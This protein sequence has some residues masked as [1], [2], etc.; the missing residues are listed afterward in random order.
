MIQYNDKRFGLVYRSAAGL[1]QPRLRFSPSPVHLRFVMDKVALSQ[2][3]LRIL[4]F[5]YLEY[6]LIYLSPTLC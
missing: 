4:Q 6:T 2:F 1:R 3:T 5:T